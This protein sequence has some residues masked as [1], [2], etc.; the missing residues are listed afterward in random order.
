[1]SQAAVLVVDDDADLR[2]LVGDFLAANNMEVVTAADAA[3]KKWVQTKS[4][5]SDRAALQRAIEA[6]LAAG[7]GR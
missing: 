3:C 2:R 5:L 6:R 7:R 1:M 4:K